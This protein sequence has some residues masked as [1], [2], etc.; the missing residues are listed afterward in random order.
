MKKEEV[1]LEELLEMRDNL[2]KIFMANY[3]VEGSRGYRPDLRIAVESSFNRF[4]E[5]NDRL[6]EEHKIKNSL[7]LQLSSNN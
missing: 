6:P 2:Y 4:N 1:K 3:N 7:I 5:V